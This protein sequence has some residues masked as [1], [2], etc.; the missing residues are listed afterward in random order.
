MIGAFNPD[1]IAEK[2]RLSKKNVPVLLIALGVPDETVLIC[3]T[4][5]SGN[6]TY[7]RDKANVHFVPKRAL[8]DVIIE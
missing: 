6:T 5:A 8:E 2:L 1:T 7:F 3:N 4:D